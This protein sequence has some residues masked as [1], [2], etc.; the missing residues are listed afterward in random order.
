M[1]AAQPQAQG[2]G[3]RLLVEHCAALARLDHPRSAPYERLQ[4]VVGQDLAHLL[5]HGLAS[6]PPRRFA[7]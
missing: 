2:R 1:F 3:A 5:V 4:A 6:G 7:A